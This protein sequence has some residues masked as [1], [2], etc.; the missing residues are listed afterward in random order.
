MRGSYDVPHTDA[1][2]ERVN[3]TIAYKPETS[4]NYEV[5]THLNLFD[6]MIHFDLSAFYMQVR[7]Q[8]L[9]VMASQY[10]FGRMMVNAGKS[11]SCGIEAA[12]RGSAISDHLNW[13]ASYGF[14]HAVFQDYTDSV[15][16]GGV[17]NVVDYKDKKVPYVPMH[18]FAANADYRFDVAPQGMLRSVT[19]GANV[20]GLGKIYWDEENEYSQKIYAVLV[21]HA[22]A[23]FGRVVLSVWGRNLT[24]TKYNTFAVKSSATGKAYTFAQ[25]GN[26]FQFGVDL[27]LHF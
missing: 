15:V 12:L 24:D 25:R 23:D 13:A 21:A 8:Q 1:D 18:T 4:W 7:N 17:T 22:D 2:Y 6:N 5:G 9:S 14:T 3:K 11:Y 10:G 19:V 16:V 27:K 20:T 26:P